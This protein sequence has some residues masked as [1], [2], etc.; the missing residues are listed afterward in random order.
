MFTIP[1]SSLKVGEFILLERENLAI[2]LGIIEEIEER[3]DGGFL[4]LSN[5]IYL[6]RYRYVPS[7]KVQMVSLEL[8]P[9]KA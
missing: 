9:L 5:S 3:K 8:S 2:P 1:E 6:Y 4:K 7:K